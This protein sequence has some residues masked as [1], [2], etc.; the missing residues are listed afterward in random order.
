MLDCNLNDYWT[1]ISKIK[2]RTIRKHDI[3]CK[4]FQFD[5]VVEF[6]PKFLVLWR[7]LYPQMW[8]KFGCRCGR[9][10]KGFFVKSLLKALMLMNKWHEQLLTNAISIVCTRVCPRVQDVKFLKRQQC[11]AILLSDI[12]HLRREV[13]SGSAQYKGFAD[14][15]LQTA[16]TEAGQLIPCF[17]S[18]FAAFI[19]ALL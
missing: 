19:P 7:P 4:S 1:W 12:G 18:L 6:C 8:W 2:L 17:K 11:K 15:L 5:G 13:Q 3:L 10:S 14:C 16:R 9:V